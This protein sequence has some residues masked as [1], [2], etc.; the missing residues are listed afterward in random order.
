MSI[1]FDAY[2]RIRPVGGTILILGVDHSQLMKYIEAKTA[3][4]LEFEV[5][6]KIAT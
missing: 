6:G 2:E 3:K 1:D 4:R 5:E